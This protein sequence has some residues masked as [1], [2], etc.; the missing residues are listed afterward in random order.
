VCSILV[1][2]YGAVFILKDAT[3]ASL[4]SFM[5]HLEVCECLPAI[6]SIYF[7]QFIADPIL[8]SSKTLGPPGVKCDMRNRNRKFFLT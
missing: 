4:V 5:F 3:V 7:N 6:D 1:E 8:F 2:V